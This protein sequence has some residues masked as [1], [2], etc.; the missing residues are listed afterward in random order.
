M[1]AT[2]YTGFDPFPL[3]VSRA[4]PFFTREFLRQ[5]GESHLGTRARHRTGHARPLREHPRPARP[6]CLP[7]RTTPRQPSCARDGRVAYPRDHT[8]HALAPMLSFWCHLLSAC[9][10]TEH[11]WFVR[12]WLHREKSTGAIELFTCLIGPFESP[13]KSRPTYTSWLGSTERRG[14]TSSCCTRTLSARQSR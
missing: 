6:T 4:H 3:I 8:G 1:C 5:G 2:Q 14:T 11:S 10:P 7:R 9:H 12:A 13:S